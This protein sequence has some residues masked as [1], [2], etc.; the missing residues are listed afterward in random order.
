MMKYLD[1]EEIGV[2]E[3]KKAIRK[4]VL[5]AEFFPVMCGT[6]LGNMGIKL[7][8]DAVVDYLPAPTDVEA[9]ECTDMK[10]NLVL[11]HPSDSEPFTA[12]A[13]KIATDPL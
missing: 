12:L 11:R 9:I 13:F 5:K 2:S 8:L 4:G 6:A 10:G 3:L 7:L 1:G